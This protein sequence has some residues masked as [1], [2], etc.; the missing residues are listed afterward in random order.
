M[1]FE[2]IET[3]EAER[4]SEKC[5]IYI[6]LPVGLKQDVTSSLSLSL[7]IEN[8]SIKN[9]KSRATSFSRETFWSF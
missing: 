4:R 5:V 2:E 7:N 6:F 3:A 9:R 1:R 8:R